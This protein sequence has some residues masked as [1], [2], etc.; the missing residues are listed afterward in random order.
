MV[1]VSGTGIV[2]ALHKGLRLYV[3]FPQ[4]VQNDMNVDIAAFVVPVHVGTHQH[5]MASKKAVGKFHADGLHS[6]SVKSTFRHIARI[7]ADDVMVRFH[8]AVILV[9]V[10]SVVELFA[11]QIEGQRLTVDPVQI[12]F[13]AQQTTAIFV[14]QLFSGFLIMLKHEIIQNRTVVG[15]LTGQMF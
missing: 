6:F 2:A 12:E 7:E 8:I 3:Q 1:F 15:T 10:K 5:L 11:L 13:R 4:T 9:F 14:Q